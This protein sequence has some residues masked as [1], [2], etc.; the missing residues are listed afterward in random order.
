MLGDT[1][2]LDIRPGP[3]PGGTVAGAGAAVRRVN[4]RAVRLVPTVYGQ[5][6][7]LRAPVH[8]DARMGESEEDRPTG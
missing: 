4:L 1:P 3:G 6:Y 7:V 8:T 2:A 5:G